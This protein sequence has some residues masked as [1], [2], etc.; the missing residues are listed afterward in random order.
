MSDPII[1]EAINAFSASGL[2]ALCDNA[3]EEFDAEA[4]VV[5]HG[6]K[7]LVHADCLAMLYVEEEEEDE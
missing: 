2:C 5:A 6:G 3:V 7:Y 1:E 4:V